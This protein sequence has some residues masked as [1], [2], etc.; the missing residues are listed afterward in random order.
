MTDSFEYYT[1]IV[2]TNATN[3]AT[4]ITLNFALF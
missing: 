3:V 4:N 2:A 1:T